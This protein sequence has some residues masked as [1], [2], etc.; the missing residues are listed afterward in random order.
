MSAALTGVTA[1]VVGVIANLGVYFAVHTLFAATTPW[2]WGPLALQVPDW[3]TLR[4]YALALTVI[5]G[6]LLFRCK[7]TVLKTPRHLRRPRARRRPA[8]CTTHLT[9]NPELN[10]DLA[11]KLTHDLHHG[12]T[13]GLGASGDKG[14]IGGAYLVRYLGQ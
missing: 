11:P 9:T 14:S 8:R 4:P 1:A 6:L 12:Q 5:E 3:S 10:N 13:E 7:L 2:S